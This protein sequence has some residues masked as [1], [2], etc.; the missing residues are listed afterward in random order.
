MANE[1]VKID[2]MLKAILSVV[3]EDQNY[4][5]SPKIYQEHYN[6]VT[7][8]LLSELSKTYP[9]SQNSVDIINPYVRFIKIPVKNGMV[10]LP[11]DYRNMLGNPSI[12]LRPDGKECGSDI[13]VNTE[14]EFKVATLRAGCKT[15]PVVIK[16]KSEW[17]ESTTSTYN[18][19]TLNDPICQF[20]G[21]GNNGEKRLQVCPYDISTVY[22]LYCKQ[23]IPIL[24]NYFAQPDE[25]FLFNPDGS[26]ESEWTD[27]AFT[28]L[29]NGLLALYSAYAKDQELANFS[30]I[31]SKAGIL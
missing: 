11:D 17:D 24:Y 22:V 12:S 10:V 27:A 2:A 30:Q 6:I 7:S 25:T 13:K 29:F 18:F 14:A 3:S 1:R 21:I 16:P 20:I 31:L 4:F 8:F 23:E 5:Y 26:I 9:S 19:P 28:P 15:R